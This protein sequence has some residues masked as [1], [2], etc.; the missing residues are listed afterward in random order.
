MKRKLGAARSVF[1]LLMTL[2]SFC[3][4]GTRD[5]PV[6]AQ[7]KTAAVNTVPR[8]APQ[9]SVT[10]VIP[11][12]SD[13]IRQVP[14]RIA[15]AGAVYELDE[16]SIFVEET[17]RGSA[18]GADVVTFTKTVEDLP[19]ND[20]IRIEKQAV[21]EGIDCELLCVVYE[22]TGEDGNKIPTAYRAVCEYG[23][24]KKYG[25]SYPVSWQ[26]SVRYDLCDSPPE[27]VPVTEWEVYES[28]FSGTKRVTGDVKNPEKEPVEETEEAVAGPAYRKFRIKPVPEKEEEGSEKIP[29]P[30]AAAV[31]GAG[32]AVPFFILIAYTTAPLFWVEREKK[33]RYIGRIRLKN[34]GGT[35]TAYLTERL[36]AKAGLPVFR[37]KLP[38]RVWKKKKGAVLYVR[39]P[40]KKKIAV[41]AGRSVVF[42]V[43]GD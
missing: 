28:S 19:D 6:H 22:V 21:F 17:G 11:L 1:G 9:E 35:Y 13:E 39:C 14:R 40:D 36:F 18:E 29:V 16:A 23:G 3:V 37:I 12:S 2:V 7:E 34:V 31:A 24:L 43:E 26:M 30:L 42:T 32:V 15:E 33:Y 10:K 8:E 38:R 20:L 27:N 5:L 25:V 4:F 41:V